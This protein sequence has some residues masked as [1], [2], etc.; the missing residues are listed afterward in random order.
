M[1]VCA[2]ASRSSNRLYVRRTLEL[3]NRDEDWGDPTTHARGPVENGKNAFF[4]RGVAASQRS[5]RNSSASGP[6]MEREWWIEYVGTLSTVPGGKK[7][8]RER[9]GAASVP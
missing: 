3:Q 4:W 7:W 6:Q 5:G 2:L 8:S 9:P 1:P